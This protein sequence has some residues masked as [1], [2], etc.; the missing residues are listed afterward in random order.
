M[1]TWLWGR[2]HVPQN[3]FL[4]LLQRS[5]FHRNKVTSSQQKLSNIL[6]FTTMFIMSTVGRARHKHGGLTPQ[7]D[8]VVDDSLVQAL[9]L[10]SD[11]YVILCIEY[12]NKCTFLQLE[13]ES[14]I[15]DLFVDS[16]LIGLFFID[17]F[18]SAS[19]PWAVTPS[20]HFGEIV[21]G[22]VVIFTGNIFRQMSVREK[23]LGICWG[24]FHRVIFTGE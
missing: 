18:Y 5:V 19:R 16:P 6:R 15:I 13:M 14:Y 8:C 4:V 1:W 24:I 10:C 12:L 20:W 22:G 7:L 2:Y 23:C 11:D 9:P 17:S 3:V 21:R